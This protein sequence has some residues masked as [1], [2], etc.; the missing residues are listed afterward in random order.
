VLAWT[1]IVAFV[2]TSLVFVRARI[3]LQTIDR[4]NAIHVL[5]D[6]TFN[7]R[8]IASRVLVLSWTAFVA[9]V[10]PSLV[11]IRARNARQAIRQSVLGLVLS[12]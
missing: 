10:G 2:G 8:N 7:A 4:T 1:A 9:F 12:N 11:F 5:T 3:A 6:T